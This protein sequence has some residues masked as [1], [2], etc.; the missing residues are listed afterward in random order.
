MMTE[1]SCWLTCE[2]G[3]TKLRDRVRKEAIMPS[4]T[5]PP[6]PDR[7]TLVTPLRLRPAPITARMT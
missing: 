1:E 2:M 4:V 5:A 7:L 6:A 3:M